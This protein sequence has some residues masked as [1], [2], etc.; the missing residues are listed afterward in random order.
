MKFINSVSGK[1][2]LQFFPFSSQHRDLKAKE[3]RHQLKR[4][5]SSFSW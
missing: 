1:L 2:E 4:A 3:N 5:A